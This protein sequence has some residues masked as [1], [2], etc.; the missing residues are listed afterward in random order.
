MQIE[1][2]TAE[3]GTISP[4]KRVIAGKKRG[5]KPKLGRSIKKKTLNVSGS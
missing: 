1:E 4:R 5:R 3:L 2:L